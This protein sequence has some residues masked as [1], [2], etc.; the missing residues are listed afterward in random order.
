MP[1]PFYRPVLDSPHAIADSLTD[2]FILLIR[3]IDI[4]LQ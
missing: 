3:T 2:L 4:C 1:V